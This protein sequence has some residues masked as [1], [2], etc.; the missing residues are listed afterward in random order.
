MSGIFLSASIPISGR[1]DFYKT[2]DPFLIQIAVREFVSAAL[3]RRKIIWGGHPAIT[4]MVWTVAEDLGIDYGKTVVL[5]Q[6]LFFEKLFP[7][8]NAYFDNVVYVDA[9]ENDLHGS[10][11][12]M[13]ERM[14][15]EEDIDAA[16]FVGGM[17]GIFEEYELV[18]KYHPAA[19]IICAPA[20]GGAALELA[21][22]LGVTQLD[23]IDFSKQMHQELSIA[24]DEKRTLVVDS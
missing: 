4:P 21:K 10:M 13:R 24:F 18:S 19:K 16:V 2:A 17:E 23:D 7:E 1:G 12:K 5:Y 20:A 3:G 14:I 8:E 9:V 15:G 22:K 11:V 6:S